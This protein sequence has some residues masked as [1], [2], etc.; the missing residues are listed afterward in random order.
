MLE[1]RA[2]S[3]SAAAACGLWLMLLGLREAY[4]YAALDYEVE[5]DGTRT[6]VRALLIAFANGREYG[7]GMTL[8]AQAGST[9]GCSTRR[10][11]KT[12]RCSRGC[13]TRGIWREVRPSGRPASSAGRIRRAVVRAPVTMEYHVDGEPGSADGDHRHRDSSTSAEGAG[14]AAAAGSGA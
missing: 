2:C 14:L 10:S 3:I 12:G 13:C 6:P 11:S 5:L 9:T 8:C 7:N 1:W 4:R